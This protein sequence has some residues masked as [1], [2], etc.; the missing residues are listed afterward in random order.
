[1][2]IKILPEEVHILAA[3]PWY[4]DNYIMSKMPTVYNLHHETQAVNFSIPKVAGC[5]LKKNPNLNGPG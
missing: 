4:G 5:Y 2:E 3:I 1:M